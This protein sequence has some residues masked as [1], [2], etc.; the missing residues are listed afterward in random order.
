MADRIK[1]GLALLLVAAGIGG[2]YWLGDQPMVLRV[3]AVLAGIGAAAA[4]AWFS[5]PGRQFFAFSKDAWAETRKV[6]WPTRK[7]TFQ[8]TGVVFLLVVVVALFLWVVD[9]SLLWAVKLLMGQ[10]D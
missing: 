1:L 10:G 7:E 3:V 8:T 9:A 2:F 6:V 5:E 4:V